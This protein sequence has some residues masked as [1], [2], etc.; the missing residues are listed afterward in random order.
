MRKHNDWVYFD[1]DPSG[2]DVYDGGKRLVAGV[3]SRNSLL[4]HT[5]E[6]LSSNWKWDKA[7]NSKLPWYSKWYTY[8][9]KEPHLKLLLCLQIVP[10]TRDQ[11]FKHM[12]LPGPFSFKPQHLFGKS[13]TLYHGHR[14][15]IHWCE[16]IAANTL[17]SAQTQPTSHTPFLFSW[18][19]EH[20]TFNTV[21]EP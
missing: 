5:Q 18:V 11:A 3:A 2:L 12:S 14:E 20:R 17:M 13:Q 16:L 15:C 19:I 10:P 21:W 9:S 7:S 1:L 8:S 4:D 6:A